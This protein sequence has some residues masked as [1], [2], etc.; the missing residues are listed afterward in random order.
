MENDDENSS[1]TSTKF[2]VKSIV[3]MPIRTSLLHI[4]GLEYLLSIL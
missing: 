1:Q 2:E 3:L 4:F